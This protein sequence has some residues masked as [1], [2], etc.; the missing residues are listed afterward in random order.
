[1]K[2]LKCNYTWLILFLCGLNF[3]L[4]HYAMLCA[5]DIEVE[6]NFTIYVD[7]FLGI[8]VDVTILFLFFYCLTWRHLKIALTI[9]FFIS[10]IWSFCNVLYSRFFHH[11]ITISAIGQGR[12]L[13]DLEMIRCVINGLCWTDLYYVF[14][15]SLFF[16]IVNSVQPVKI[17]LAK[18][19]VSFLIAIGVYFCSY[20]VYCS[21]TP[22]FR[23]LSFF[24]HRIENGQFSSLLHL[25]NPNCATFRRGSIRTLLFELNQNLCGIIELT[26]E[27]R[28]QIEKTVV[29][30]NKGIIKRHNGIS[31]D[32]VIFILVESYMS[33]TSDMKAGGREITP[34]LNSLKSDTAVYYNGKMRENVTIGE[35]SDGQFIYMAGLLPLRSIVTVSK[36][37][38]VTL[39]GLPKMFA[40]ESRMVIPTV[41]SM[42]NQN[43]MCR[44]YG[45]DYL[46]SSN[47]YAGGNYKFLNDEQVFQ[48]AMQK[49]KNT[50]QPFFS[51]ILTM[52]MHQPYTMQIDSTFQIKD[53]SISAELACYLNACHYTDR[54]ISKYID[55]LKKTGLY[56]KS[57][58]VIA[59]DHPVHNTD[60]GGVKSDIP[61][62]LV[63]IPQELRGRMWQGECNQIDVYTTLLDLL[64]VKS[65]W[66]GMGQSL[67]SPNFNSTV[68]PKK[69]E[70]SEWIIRGD[71]FSNQ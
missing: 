49:D 53:S 31:R 18:M 66:F 64:D 2:G 44:Q 29:E 50:C 8:V 59:A 6:T 14:C 68:D 54:Q 43:E 1:M 9:T 32:N 58:I 63:N 13:M 65:D 37:C 67:L 56:E 22:D 70:V 11:Y 24:I 45:F 57:L 34:F 55:H 47:D 39:Y 40:K 51:V 15:T 41:T 48:L 19:V 4:M 60:F 28:I 17:L 25:S 69:W 42:W 23:Y 52:S 46:Y 10:M 12:N 35:S 30:A 61:F 26:K 62:Y 33:F 38:D 71:Y 36:A 7:N 16:F 3:F 5:D 27:Q 20:I 21:I